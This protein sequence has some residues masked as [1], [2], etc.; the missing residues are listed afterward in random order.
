MKIRRESAILK[1]KALAS[2]RRAL[3]RFNSFEDDGRTCAVL[4]DTQHA[5][6]MLLKAGL[7]QRRVGVFDKRVGRSIGFEKCLNLASEHLGLSA[8]SAGTL[9][10]IDALRDEEQ[11]WHA[12]VSEGILYLHMRAAVTLFDDLLDIAF[13]ERLASHLPRRVLPLSVEAPR[14]IQL[15]IDEEY[16][17]IESL[18]RPGRRRRPEA[19]G[20]IRAL[21][22]LE[23]H[24]VP[25]TMVSSKDVARVER[26]AR[27]GKARDAVFPKLEELTSEISGEGIELT[28]RFSKTEGMPVRYTADPNDD[29]AAI[30]EVDLQ[31]KFHLS[32]TALAATLSLTLPK[33][34]ALRRAAGVDDDPNCAHTFRFN[35]SS[36]VMYSDN[37]VRKMRDLLGETTI[38]DIWREHGGGRRS[39][40]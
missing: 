5:F 20:R 16:R 35:K 33:S 10:A 39:R 29:A 17:Q 12:V 21:L 38:E 31:K 23:A 19:Q 18:L 7:T 30:R 24:A 13:T 6:E 26:A 22:A 34:G 37:A 11:H 28:V 15:L 1:S 36:F 9:R 3:G 4:L 2:L 32:A 40:R 25:E 27:A 8:G 14:D